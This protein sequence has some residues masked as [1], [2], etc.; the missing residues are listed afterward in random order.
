MIA[1]LEPGPQ[2]L[3]LQGFFPTGHRSSTL[4]NKLGHPCAPTILIA[5]LVQKLPKVVGPHS[6]ATMALD[7]ISATTTYV[8]WREEHLWGVSVL[9][10]AHLSN[11]IIIITVVFICI[12]KV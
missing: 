7:R 10:T 6:C 4:A 2:R 9:Q 1:S 3:L 12:I 5:T 8:M 11:F